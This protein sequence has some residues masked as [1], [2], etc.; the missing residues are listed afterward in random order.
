MASTVSQGRPAALSVPDGKVRGMTIR[1][2]LFDLD[3]TLVDHRGA[4]E[5]GLRAWL[6]GLALEGPLEEHVERW[7]ALE[8]R[9]YERA[10]RGEISYVEHRRARIRGF[11]PSWDLADDALA[12]ATYAGF[13]GC[14]QAAWRAHRDAGPALQRAHDHGLRVGILTNGEQHIQ[15]RK[16]RRTG[17]AAYDVPVLA[18]SALPAAKPDPRAFHAACG[19]LG[20]DPSETVMIGDSLRNDVRG[21]HRAGLHA[22]L[23]DR[24][25]RYA[26][27][28]LPGAARITR[29]RDLAMPGA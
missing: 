14:Y 15:E 13:L 11:L 18:S 21:A 20:A 9:H 4:A 27:K 10:Q 23:L 16:V 29:L 6:A 2:V 8:V 5:R 24:S 7:F 19:R 17:L 25:G 22:V 1:A 12:D 3:D 26:G 28:T